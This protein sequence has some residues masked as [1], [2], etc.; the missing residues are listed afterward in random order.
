MERR[1]P[2][3]ADARRQRKRPK[4]DISRTA[5]G[6]TPKKRGL[7][8][9]AAE[10]AERAAAKSGVEEKPSAPR[11]FAVRVKT[12]R[13]RK[14][15]STLWLQRQ[16][17]DPYVARAKAEGYRSRAAYKLTELDEKFSLLKPGARVVDLGCAPGGWLQV[18]AKRAGPGA[19][20]VGIDYLETAGVAG[21]DILMLDFLDPGAADRLKSALGGAAASAARISLA[22]KG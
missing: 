15:S 18:A 7:K 9:G 19:K 11:E 1:S 2:P 3:R 12:A 16:L 17:N 21:A 5:L 10:A 14:L 13:D 8:K 20:I 4:V 6:E 22:G